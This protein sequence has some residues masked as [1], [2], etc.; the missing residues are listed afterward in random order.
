MGKRGAVCID[1][2]NTSVKVTLFGPGGIETLAVERT[3]EPGA[4]RRIERMLRAGR[5]APPGG[6]DAILCTVV[7]EMGTVL[8]GVVR[9]ALGVKPFS[10][11]HT[12]VLP[13][14]LAVEQPSKVGPDR[15]CAA[16]GVCAGRRG[17]R[18][19]HAIIVDI[20]SAV[21]VDLLSGGRFCGGLIFVG[22]VLGLNALGEYARRLPR[23]NPARMETA[24]GKD[25]SDTEPSMAL[26]A[27][28]ST[29]GAIKEAVKTLER[30]AGR[31]PPVY[32]TGGWARAVLRHLP[33][34]WRHDPD[35]VT[36]GMIAIR[37][38]NR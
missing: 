11:R 21:T 15:L 12:R 4:A 22:P 36:K 33:P 24:T 6:V 19:Q 34:S 3:R 17:R 38:L 14:T 20:G 31:R 28:V 26:G 8:S 5:R 10:I 7:P 1:V 37:K 9:S 23:V 13:F 30:A 18:I 32:I 25:F 27:R 35:L 29:V 2:G 16:A